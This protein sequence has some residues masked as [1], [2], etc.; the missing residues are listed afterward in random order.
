LVIVSSSAAVLAVGIFGSAIVQA[1]FD[2]A[3]QEDEE[4]NCNQQ[5]YY[6]FFIIV[7]IFII[8]II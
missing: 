1:H 8:I 4:N 3:E 2:C 5:S 7:I 6:I